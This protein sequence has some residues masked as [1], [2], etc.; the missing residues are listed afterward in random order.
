MKERE[1][2][3]AE[4]RRN[5]PFDELERKW[6]KARGRHSNRMWC[7]EELDL[8][9]AFGKKFADLFNRQQDI[10]P[11]ISKLFDENFFDAIMEYV[12]PGNTTDT[13]NMLIGEVHQRIRSSEKSIAELIKAQE[14]DQ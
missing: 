7:A 3:I 2:R 11:R 10:D 9:H 14:A 6:K 8:A 5:K 13:M 4:Y 1:E 12:P